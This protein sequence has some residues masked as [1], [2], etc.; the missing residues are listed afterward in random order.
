MY[1]SSRACGLST[2]IALAIALALSG[3]EPPEPE[4]DAG[5]Q[6]CFVGDPEQAP[7]LQLVYRTAEGDLADLVE[8]A[9]VPLIV[10]PQGGMVVAIGA[11]LRNVNI[12]GLQMSA[13]L[14]DTCTDRILGR[15]GR[16][17]HLEKSAEGWALPIAP[18]RLDNYVNINACPNLVSSRD[19]D[20]EPYQLE[21]RAV[22]LNTDL[23][24]TS[25]L[26]LTTVCGEPDAERLCECQCDADYVLG[27]DDCYAADAGAALWRPDPDVPPGTCPDIVDA[28]PDSEDAGTDAGS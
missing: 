28:G 4:P 17:I 3:C 9:E 1:P 22:N 14:R 2:V 18:S 10:P 27:R 21:L 6:D 15:E 13:L 19:L 16:P 25:Q 24:M 7:E 12:C 20:Q 8:G 11:R 5:P 23:S 26:T